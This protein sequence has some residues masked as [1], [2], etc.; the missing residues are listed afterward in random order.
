MM[1][2]EKYVP[3]YAIRPLPPPRRKKKKT[4][5]A[6]HPRPL[7]KVISNGVKKEH[8]LLDTFKY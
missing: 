6:D 3:K 5:V 7:L 2:A 4:C 1:A 8:V